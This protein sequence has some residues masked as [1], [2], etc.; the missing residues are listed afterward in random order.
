MENKSKIICHCKQVSEQ[1]IM[2]AVDNGASN[3]LQ[4]QEATQAV[5]GCKSC[6]KDVMHVFESY[7]RSKKKKRRY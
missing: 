5:T 2:D 7:Q 3:Y 6:F 1:D 4:L